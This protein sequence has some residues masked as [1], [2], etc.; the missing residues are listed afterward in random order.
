M[1]F[2]T[3]LRHK[4]QDEP[5]GVRPGG[6]VE[7][8]LRI[9]AA[10]GMTQSFNENFSQQDPPLLR[11]VLLSVGAAPAVDTMFAGR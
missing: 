4:I 1:E 9:A 2:P 10:P 7:F 8:I 5:T 6:V 3:I 11:V